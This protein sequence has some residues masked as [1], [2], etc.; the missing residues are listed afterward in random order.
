VPGLETVG[1]ATGSEYAV[2]ARHLEGALWEVEAT[3]L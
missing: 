2:R 1:D 3:P